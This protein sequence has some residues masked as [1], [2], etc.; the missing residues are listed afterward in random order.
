MT[1][2]NHPSYGGKA[3]TRVIPSDIP[4]FDL[5]GKYDYTL[6]DEKFFLHSNTARSR[7]TFAD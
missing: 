1:N 5:Y 3:V 2:Q 7:G 4:Y 6:Q